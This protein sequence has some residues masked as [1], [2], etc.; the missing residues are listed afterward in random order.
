M[1]KF[2]YF[3]VK[4]QNSNGKT[5]EKPRSHVIRWIDRD[6][7]RERILVDQKTATLRLLRFLCCSFL[8]YFFHSGDLKFELQS[9][10]LL[11]E[12]VRKLAI[13]CFPDAFIADDP[14]VG[15]NVFL[16]SC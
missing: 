1:K 15:Y 8:Y 5:K 4:S 2:I 7:K 6:L 12:L 16:Y 13:H 10:T 11:S 9:R 14:E 3:K